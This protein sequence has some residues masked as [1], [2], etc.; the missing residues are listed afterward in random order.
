MLAF[1]GFGRTLDDFKTFKQSLCSQYNIHGFNLFHHGNAEYP[2]DRITSNTLTKPELKD[3]LAAYLE[4]HN[5]ERFSLLAYSIGGRVALC[6][7]EW[8]PEKVD[9][10]YLYAPH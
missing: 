9:A 10:V 1:H 4:A 3:M 6:M 8:F 2:N 7:M 5:I